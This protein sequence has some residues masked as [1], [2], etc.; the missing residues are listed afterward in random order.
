[1][2]DHNGDAPGWAIRLIATVDR[3]GEKIDTAHLNLAG[4]SPRV[5]A[6]EQHAEKMEKH[7]EATDGRVD[8]VEKAIGEATASAK[9]V[10]W[11]V[12]TL[13]TFALWVTGALGKFADFIANRGGK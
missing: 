3:L 13:A 4:I 7:L 10:W 9:A 1:M 6:L 12:G 8:D 5:S 11:A 2:T